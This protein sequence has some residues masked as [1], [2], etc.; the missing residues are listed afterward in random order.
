MQST[1][2]P[3]PILG[4]AAGG[5]FAGAVLGL[6]VQVLFLQRP[7][8]NQSILLIGPGIGSILL[9]IVAVSFG[10]SELHGWFKIVSIS[11]LT[12][13]VVGAVCGT[14][15]YPA[16]REAIDG[17]DPVF[18]GKI[19]AFHANVGARFGIPIGGILGI[20][21]GIGVWYWRSD[22]VSGIGSP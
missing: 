11:C 5:L 17:F 9:A 6:I 3:I 18:H 4:R 7:P 21:I 20:L 15:I 19:R 22:R 14:T 13:I 16:I 10:G 12:G 8:E 2:P 1:N